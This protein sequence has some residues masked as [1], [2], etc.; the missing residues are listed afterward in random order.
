MMLKVVKRCFVSL[1]Q[2]FLSIYIAAGL[3]LGF[4]NKLVYLIPTIEDW[5]IKKPSQDNSVKK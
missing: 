3:M 1:Q 5:E 4:L 2:T